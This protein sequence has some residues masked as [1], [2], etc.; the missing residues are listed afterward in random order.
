MI[1]CPE[2][3]LVSDCCRKISLTL[4][5]RHGSGDQAS[6]L[7]WSKQLDSVVQCTGKFLIVLDF[8]VTTTSTDTGVH[9]NTELVATLKPKKL[10]ELVTTVSPLK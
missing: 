3:L 6:F 7:N 10:G 2:T 1:P 9:R 5:G 4:K 8:L